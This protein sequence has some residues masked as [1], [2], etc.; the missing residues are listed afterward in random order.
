MTLTIQWRRRPIGDEMRWRVN[1][2]VGGKLQYCV[3]VKDWFDSERKLDYI[4]RYFARELGH[5]HRVDLL[6]PL[7][8]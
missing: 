1:V 3:F 2:L 4:R 5:G 8:R 6:V 7:Q